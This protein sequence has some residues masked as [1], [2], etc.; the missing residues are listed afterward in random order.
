MSPFS[1]MNATSRVRSLTTLVVLILTGA[2]LVAEA[3]QFVCWPIAHG[4]TASGL[5]LRLTGDADTAYTDW[6]QIREPAR[7]RF[8]PKSRYDR[9][10]TRW[11]AC[12]ARDLLAIAPIPRADVEPRQNLSSFSTTL[13]WQVG[14]GVSLTL[15]ACSV[16]VKYVP[17]RAIPPD[18]QRTGEA[19]V[20]AF[21]RPL[22]D[23]SGGA[24]PIKARLRFVRRA[25]QLEIC[26]APNAG[27][28]YPNLLDHKTNVEYDVIRVVQLLGTHVVVSDRLRTE[29]KWV[30]I[31]IRHADVKQAG[32]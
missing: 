20:S 16:I 21:A 27:R 11:Q 17:A 6:F 13:M 4:D 9:L 2:P 31:P 23:P 10:S 28:R 1:A 29:G 22:I 5:A 14:L 24:P 15:F 7:G 26:I 19:F 32:G 12:I 3:Q 18:M 30:V 8:V 25:E